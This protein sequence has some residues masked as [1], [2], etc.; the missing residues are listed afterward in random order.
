MPIILETHVWDK[1]PTILSNYDLSRREDLVY[2]SLHGGCLATHY[3]PPS[4]TS[5]VSHH[6]TGHFFEMK[7]ET[8][9]T[10]SAYGFIL[11]DK[12]ILQELSEYCHL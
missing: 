3:T 6:H 2:T 7:N 12:L 4:R 1:G 11:I 8:K 10:T 9:T 5:V